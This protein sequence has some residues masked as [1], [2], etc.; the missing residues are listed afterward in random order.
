MGET[1]LLDIGGSL[2]EPALEAAQQRALDVVLQQWSGPVA[3]YPNSGDFVYPNWQFDTVCA[4]ETFAGA[5]EGWIERGARLV[6]G[7]CGVGPA[8][9]E[10]LRKRLG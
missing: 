4:P 3:V 7:C 5:A 2:A 1:D 6:G 8:H 9:I 10:A